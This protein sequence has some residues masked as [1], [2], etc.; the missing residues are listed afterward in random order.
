MDL[1]A[2]L[3]YK[4]GY[5]IITPYLV[6]LE[7]EAIPTNAVAYDE[8]ATV[9]SALPLLLPYDYTSHLATHHSTQHHVGGAL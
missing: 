9:P 6:L 3:Y 8:G 7:V 2:I 4:D 1:P 5:H